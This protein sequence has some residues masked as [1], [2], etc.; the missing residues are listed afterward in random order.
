MNAPLPLLS[1]LEARVLGVLVE[2]QHTV[3]DTYPLTLNAL[4]AGCN[5]KT[6]R[7]PILN[8]TDAEVQVAIDR[9]KSLSLVVE[10]SGG[11]VMRYAH[12]AERALGVPSQSVALLATFMLRGTQTVGE[13]RINSERL[14]RFADV[15]AVAA[16]LRELAER[17]D[18]PMVAELPRA[19]GER[20]NRWMHL[21][22]GKPAATV[23]APAAA[24]DVVSL[25]ELAALRQSVDQLRADLERLEANVAS[26][27]KELGAAS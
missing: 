19:P 22:C 4:T 14:H 10:S 2:K 9:L 7:D 20:E 5:Q 27:R 12:N 15:S 23:A 6:S 17:A 3:P 24:G 8:A 26:L 16:F 11:R 18:A 1:L 25:T 21:L 13:L